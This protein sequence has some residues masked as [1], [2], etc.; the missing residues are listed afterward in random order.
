MV[1][2]REYY[3]EENTPRAQDV[4]PAAFGAVRDG[5][6]RLLLVRRID[7]GN[8]ELPGGRIE[9]G[10][11]AVEALA[12]EVAEE[13]GITLEVTGI[14][15]VYSDPTHVLEDPGGIVHQQL[16][17]CFHAAPTASA[18][19]GQ[20]RPDGIETDAA[21]WFAPDELADLRIHPAMRL[22]IDHALRVPRRP[23]VEGAAPETGGEPPPLAV[24]PGGVLEQR[25]SA[26]T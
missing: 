20:P 24:E 21:A 7:D 2:I 16:A 14:A 19:G 15:G 11:S 1:R 8:W 17:L 23:F 25:Q 22:R 13:S 5:A 18:D 10:E 9:V 12:R 6:G 26:T 3:R 4:L